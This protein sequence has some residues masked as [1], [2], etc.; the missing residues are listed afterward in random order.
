MY[1]AGRE[2]RVRRKSTI[3]AFFSLTALHVHLYV[4]RISLGCNLTYRV[5]CCVYHL[6]TINTSQF[7]SFLFHIFIEHHTFCN[8]LNLWLMVVHVHVTCT[9]HVHL[10]L[11]GTCST[12][13]MLV[14]SYWPRTSF[15]DI[16]ILNSFL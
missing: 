1:I 8:L 3:L 7:M 5:W 4:I 13:A 6:L 12:I 2:K 14:H 9:V 15:A 10:C 16:D 11:A